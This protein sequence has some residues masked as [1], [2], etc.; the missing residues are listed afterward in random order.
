M[1]QEEQGVQVGKYLFNENDDVKKYT[2]KKQIIW[3]FLQNKSKCYRELNN[4]V[5][6][7]CDKGV[8]HSQGSV[9]KGMKAVM[10]R[11][12]EYNGKI[13]AITKTNRGYALLDQDHY[14][15]NL[16][17]TLETKC[18][19]KCKRVFYE[20]GLNKPQMFVFW[21]TEDPQV[22]EET[23]A[24]FEMVLNNGF[25]DIFYIEDKL[26]IL[27]DCKSDRFFFNCDL[28][29]KFFAKENDPF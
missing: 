8:P 9:S 24:L 2:V 3:L 22:R 4:I 19:F 7:L 14:P 1:M 28:L 18:A 27:L 6:A 23:K 25:L 21:I 11:P 17:Y 10:Q 12:F 26:I 13:Y 20:E 5:E 16:R 15:R 29:K